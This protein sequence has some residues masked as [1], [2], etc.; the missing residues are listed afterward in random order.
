MSSLVGR[1]NN[2]GAEPHDPLF[3]LESESAATIQHLRVYKEVCHKLRSSLVDASN[4]I[5][6]PTTISRAL[7]KE[8]MEK[9]SVSC[10]NGAFLGEAP[11]A[12]CP[13]GAMEYGTAGDSCPFLEAAEGWIIEYSKSECQVCYLEA[14]VA[15][16]CLVLCSEA[17]CICWVL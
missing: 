12:N 3:E 15:G 4:E 17:R 1:A 6:S 11:S 13:G 14:G 8:S 2:G 10:P 7:V 9:Q 5:V 16:M